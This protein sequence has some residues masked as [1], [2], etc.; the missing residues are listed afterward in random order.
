MRGMIIAAALAFPLIAAAGGVTA[1][2]TLPAGTL[3]APGDL[4]PDPGANPAGADAL[5]GLETRFTIYAGRH[6]DPAQLREPR[7]IAR[8]QIAPL[9]F[10]RGA[11]S[12]ET[13]GR[14]LAEGGAGEVIPVM[15]LNSRQ[16]VSAEIAPDG[17][18]FISR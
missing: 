5:V 7:L 2:R 3:I 16:T 4:V 1:S 17:T 18:L 11:L 9:V 14:A 12:I 6:V 15:T 13:S 8:N 10:R